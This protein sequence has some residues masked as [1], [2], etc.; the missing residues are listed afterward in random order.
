MDIG[1]LTKL[2][3]FVFGAIMWTKMQCYKDSG[4]SLLSFSGWLA[5]AENALTRVIPTEVGSLGVT[6]RKYD[7]H[8][9]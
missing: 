3:K 1:Q 2:R 8:N 5:L 4:N 9:T 6:L 7:A